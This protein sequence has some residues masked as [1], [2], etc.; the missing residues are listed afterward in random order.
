MEVD[1]IPED[2]N[3]KASL[4]IGGILLRECGCLKEGEHD[5]FIMIAKSSTFGNFERLK[6]RCLWIK[7]IQ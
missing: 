1:D 3:K 5:W 2:A 4:I 7:Y 6:T